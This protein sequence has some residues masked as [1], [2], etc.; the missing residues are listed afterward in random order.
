MLRDLVRENTDGSCSGSRNGNDTD[1][2]FGRSG[3]DTIRLS[4][5]SLQY[6]AWDASDTGTIDYAIDWQEVLYICDINQIKK[7]YL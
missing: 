2:Y 3:S 5:E 1:D 7:H 6:I 4:K